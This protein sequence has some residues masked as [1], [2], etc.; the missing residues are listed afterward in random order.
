[1]KQRMDMPLQHD[2]ARSKAG[3]RRDG[4]QQSG[5]DADFGP[6]GTATVLYT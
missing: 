6:F 4:R 1:M 3:L 2:L 5:L